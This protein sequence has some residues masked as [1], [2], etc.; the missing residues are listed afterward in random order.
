MRLIQILFLLAVVSSSSVFAYGPPGTVEGVRFSCP[1]LGGLQNTLNRVVN[2]QQV[3]NVNTG[4]DVVTNDS[5]CQIQFQGVDFLY[6]QE[7]ACAAQVWGC[8]ETGFKGW[9]LTERFIVSVW[10]VG[11]PSQTVLH[12]GREKKLGDRMHWTAGV[13]YR[14]KDARLP[15]HC[16]ERAYVIEGVTLYGHQFSYGNPLDEA[17]SFFCGAPPVVRNH[18]RN[19]SHENDAG[20]EWRTPEQLEALRLLQEMRQ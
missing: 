1:T 19:P 5:G 17:G 9:I 20:R 12:R 4:S 15:R 10:R 2:E 18:I 14:R 11:H 16:M 3:Y 6:T 7:E 8:L 13:M